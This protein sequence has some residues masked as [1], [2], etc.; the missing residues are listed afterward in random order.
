MT[1]ESAMTEADLMHLRS[2][3]LALANQ[4]GRLP[5]QVIEGARAYVDFILGTN[6]RP[7]GGV[8]PG[9][10]VFTAGEGGK[11]VRDS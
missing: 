3:A 6:V 10:V 8:K 9:T 1:Q 5:D 2:T 4:P 7:A 11:M